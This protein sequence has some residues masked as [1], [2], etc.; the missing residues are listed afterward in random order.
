MHCAR[1]LQVRDGFE[2]C[3]EGEGRGSR[4][5]LLFAGTPTSALSECTFTLRHHHRHCHRRRHRCL[6]NPYPLVAF[7]PSSA[8]VT[9]G[10]TGGYSGSDLKELCRAALM[11][12]IRELAAAEASPV[13]LDPPFVDASAAHSAAAAAT[14]EAHASA[15]EPNGSNDSKSNLSQ[16]RPLRRSDFEDALG[17]VGPTGASAHEFM[18][19]EQRSGGPGSS[20]RVAAGGDAGHEA[21]SAGAGVS[22][23]GQAMMNVFGALLAQMVRN[24]NM[25][26]NMAMGAGGPG[27]GGPGAGIGGDVGGG[28]RSGGAPRRPR[29][30]SE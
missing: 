13:P 22:V 12:P 17:K 5:L 29:P 6:N 21:G 27:M 15:A 18:L 24:N 7:I 9:Q 1:T 2:D 16:P 26:S 19:R 10:V 8:N 3:G 14:R 4:T 28:H 25:G 30:P 23:D 11:Q 20:A